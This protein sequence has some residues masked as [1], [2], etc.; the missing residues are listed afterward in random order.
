MIESIRTFFSRRWAQLR[1]DRSSQIIVLVALVTFPPAF[2]Y[3][4]LLVRALL[5][6]LLV[7]VLL[8]RS[9]LSS[10]T[11][12]V[13]SRLDPGLPPPVAFYRLFLRDSDVQS[14]VSSLRWFINI[15]I[16][17]LL[18]GN[19]LWIPLVD[20]FLGFCF[21]LIFS[22]ADELHIRGSPVPGQPVDPSGAPG[23]GW[24]SGYDYAMGHVKNNPR[25]AVL[26]TVLGAVLGYAGKSILDGVVQDQ[27][28]SRQA[29]RQAAS[30]LV[31]A[32]QKADI[33]VSTAQRIAQI[34]RI[35]VSTADI[36][37]STAQQNADI[38]VSTAQQIAQI[39]RDL[40][41][42]QTDNK[43]RV[44]EAQGRLGSR[45]PLPS[46]FPRSA[47]GLSPLFPLSCSVS[48]PLSSLLPWK[49]SFSKVLK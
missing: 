12:L 15:N 24:R 41:T 19:P 4:Q 6:A 26:L 17:L 49:L 5:L 35:Q 29:V 30:D 25:R 23:S 45:T 42:W 31:L 21:F 7:F 28:A 32:Q 1:R 2:Y 14:L 39:Q 46:A 16:C 36:Q 8:V 43:I 20:V 18:L 38:Q 34:Q 44:L 27:L 3:G 11:Q 22:T 37:M 33:Q 40:D 13:S 48:S 47:S 10:W 9:T